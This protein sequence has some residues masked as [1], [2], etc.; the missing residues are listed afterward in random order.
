ML[1]E[2]WVNKYQPLNNL[3]VEDAPF[4]EKMFETYGP[5]LDYVRD[6]IGK[7]TVWTIVDAEEKLYLIAGFHIVNRLGYLITEIPWK[8][9]AGENLEIEID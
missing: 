7:N 1:Y 3:L 9:E 4:G 5:E 8:D 2:E 6:N